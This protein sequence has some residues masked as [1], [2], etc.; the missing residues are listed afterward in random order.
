MGGGGHPPGCIKER[1]QRV[2]PINGGGEKPLQGSPGSA[3]RVN[4]MARKARKENKK[5][6]EKVYLD[7]PAYREFLV[8][9]FFKEDEDI[10]KVT[11]ELAK[12]FQEKVEEQ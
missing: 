9:L 3:P 10:E 7:D 12:I 4:R 1:N 2:G 8:K 5:L 11:S 6:F